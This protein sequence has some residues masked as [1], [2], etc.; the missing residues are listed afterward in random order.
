MRGMRQPGASLSQHRH[1]GKGA[2]CLTVEREAPSAA[3]VIVACST[4]MMQGGLCVRRLVAGGVLAR[5]CFGVG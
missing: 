1:T 5:A 3:G 4:A 2:C